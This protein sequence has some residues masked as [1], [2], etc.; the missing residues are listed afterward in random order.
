ME[1]TTFKQTANA[2][3]VYDP[4]TTGQ[5]FGAFVKVINSQALFAAI[6]K[7]FIKNFKIFS[8]I[9]SPNDALNWQ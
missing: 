2:V 1:F 3:I 8:T 5:V 9:K 6:K 4:R 7:Q